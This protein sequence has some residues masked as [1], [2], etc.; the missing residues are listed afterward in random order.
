[1]RVSLSG[2]WDYTLELECMQGEGGAGLAGR[3]KELE[4][5]GRVQRETIQ[6]QAMRIE[7]VAL[8]Y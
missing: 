8:K 7:V 2:A 6:Q 3:C 1:M 4:E 5:V